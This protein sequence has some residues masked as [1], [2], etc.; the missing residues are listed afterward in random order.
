MTRR[1]QYVKFTRVIT[2]LVLAVLLLTSSLPARAS[3]QPL[4]ENLSGVSKT[5]PIVIR[6]YYDNQT[7]LNAVAGE[8]DIWE[9]HPI[10][11]LGYGPGYVVAEVTPDQQ[12]WLQS[13]GYRVELDLEKTALVQSPTAAL[14]PRYYYFDDIF[15]NSYDRYM[16]D[17]LQATSASYPGITE[18]LDVGD[19]WGASHG[20]HPRDM[21]ILRIS[22]E[23]SQ[24]GDIADKPIFFLFAAIHAREVSTPEMAIR[25]IKYLTEGYLGQ[26]GYGLDP[27]V[28][29][30]V[31]HHVTYIMVSM[32]PD[33]HFMNE[34]DTSIGYWG[35]RKNVDNDD[36][37]NDP[38]SW[39]VDLNRNSSFYWSLGG[40]SSGNPCSET[41][42]GPNVASE[43]ETIAFQDFA[44]SIFTDWNG[45]NADDEIVPSPDD[46]SGIFITLHSYADEILWPFGFAPGAA[47]NDD[48]LRTIGR[49]LADITTTMYPSG[50]VGYPVDGASDDWIYGHFGIAAFT[51]EIGPNYGSCGG[52]FPAYECQDGSGV[53]RN[54]WYEV[55]PSFMYATKIA[56]SPYKTTYGPDA[57]NL[58]VDPTSVPPA[59]PVDLTA[60]IVDQRYEDDDLVPI[61]AAEYFID[62]PGEDGAGIAMSPEDGEWG[63]TNENV[64]AVVDTT[65]LL[66]GQHYILVHG[67]NADGF[68]GPLTAVFLDVTGTEEPIA[69]F[70]SNS[71]V[72]LGEQMVFTNT[73]TGSEPMTYEWDFGD[74]MGTSTEINPTYTYTDTGSYIVIL[75]AT[76]DLGSD[77]ISHTVSVEP[78][79]IT[80]VELTRVTT[81]T[82]YAGDPVDF[83]LDLSPDDAAKP[84]SYSLDFGDGTVVTGTSEMEPLFFY[85]VFITGGVY[86]A[87]AAVKNE[88]MPD[89]IFDT[90]T[91]YVNFEMFLPFTTK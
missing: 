83:M 44:T 15:Y 41:Y 81:D 6:L 10:I 66:E 18:L 91:I 4:T 39:G 61:V 32:N 14:D 70:I 47:P 50:Y 26:G 35:W 73:T 2:T 60:T 29:W 24:Y 3:D 36:D 40:G 21:W 11:R 16:V 38:E 49:K 46:A 27:D 72:F 34:V 58:V 37:C 84:F 28:T 43:P 89:P 20:Q 78:G 45:D 86:T 65:S 53:S 69:D 1:H 82:A 64:L 17:F 31:N 90:L 77:S 85:H 79:P 63:E 68:W 55:S 5:H 57:Q 54:F 48:Q 67:M 13:L 76:N 80:S 71:P 88:A 52:F 75:N 23:D 74:G 62:A 7:Q 25:Y 12:T 9:V 22:N 19:A 51:Y 87:Q 33:G 56:G 42:R 8:L 59:V 30:L